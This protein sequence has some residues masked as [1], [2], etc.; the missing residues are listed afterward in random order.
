MRKWRFFYLLAHVAALIVFSPPVSV[1]R[2]V[3]GCVSG[4]FSVSI[5]S[6]CGIRPFCDA[7]PNA[8]KAF[9][10]LRS[11]LALWFPKASVGFQT[12]GEQSNVRFDVP[13]KREWM[14]FLRK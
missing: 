8:W 1:H 3:C 11:S 14:N 12:R 9:V 10:R 6:L 4:D 2:R 13:T 7:A 5:F